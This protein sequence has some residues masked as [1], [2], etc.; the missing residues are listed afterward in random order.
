[1]DVANL[2]TEPKIRQAISQNAELKTASK[3]FYTYE[4]TLS[5]P[6]VIK[7]SYTKRCCTG[8]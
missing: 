3:G 2:I 8:L 1:M 4:A 6:I 5:K 7:N